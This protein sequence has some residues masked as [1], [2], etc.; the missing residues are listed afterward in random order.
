MQELPLQEG[1]N[2]EDGYVGSIQK[3]LF[4]PVFALY[5]CVCV[6]VCLCMYA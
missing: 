1:D 4:E 6:C 5:V 2:D 3:S